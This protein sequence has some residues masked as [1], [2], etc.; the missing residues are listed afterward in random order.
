[1]IIGFL[2]RVLAAW[3]PCELGCGPFAEIGMMIKWDAESSS[4]LARRCSE[5]SQNDTELAAQY[6]W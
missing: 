2:S 5:R 3:I 1:M 4:S 6:G